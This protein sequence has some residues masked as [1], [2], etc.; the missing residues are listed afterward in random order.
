MCALLSQHFIKQDLYLKELRPR[1]GQ[2]LATIKAR[3]VK[4]QCVEEQA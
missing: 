3:D 2:Q 4:E 1:P